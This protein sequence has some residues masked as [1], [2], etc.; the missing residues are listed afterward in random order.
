VERF[1]I[2]VWDE[3][4]ESWDKDYAIQFGWDGVNRM[5]I[6]FRDAEARRRDNVFQ[7]GTH[8]FTKLA[9]TA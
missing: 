7:S 1:F 2:E 8:S 5:P 4:A 3:E 9:P 6:F